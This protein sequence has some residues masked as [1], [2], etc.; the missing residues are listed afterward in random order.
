[1]NSI[2][3]EAEPRTPNDD[4]PRTSRDDDTS[5]ESNI[6]EDAAQI[7]WE[8][9]EALDDGA[10]PDLLNEATATGADPAQIPADDDDVPATDLP[11][12]EAQPETRGDD[13]IVAG[14]GEDGEGDLAPQDI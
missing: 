1:M 12:D 5:V 13:P 2:P 6:E 8:R 14:L 9:T 4:A 7:E 3:E 11:P 10:D